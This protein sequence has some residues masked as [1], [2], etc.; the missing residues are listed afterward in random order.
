MIIIE[1]HSSILLFIIVSNISGSFSNHQ[2]QQPPRINHNPGGEELTS[3]KYMI[4]VRS[5][6]IIDHQIYVK[7][8]SNYVGTFPSSVWGANDD[9][10]SGEFILSDCFGKLIEQLN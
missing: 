9:I 6:T 1:N 10:G 7:M 4:L 2:D 8:I 3:G 5:I